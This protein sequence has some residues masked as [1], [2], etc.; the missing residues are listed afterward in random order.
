MMFV[1]FVIQLRYQ[2]IN[3]CAVLLNQRFFLTIVLLTFLLFHF[4]DIRLTLHSGQAFG[5]HSDSTLIFHHHPVYIGSLKKKSCLV[6]HNFIPTKFQEDTINTVS[7][8]ILKI[9]HSYLATA[10]VQTSHPC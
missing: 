10:N 2:T 1:F 5:V 4:F 7:S 6:P 3:H 8:H 9:I